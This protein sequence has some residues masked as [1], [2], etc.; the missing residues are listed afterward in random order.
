MEQVEQGVPKPAD[1]EIP[2]LVA[3]GEA[4]SCCR[5][6]VRFGRTILADCQGE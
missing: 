4:G 3:G 2:A 5:S 6:Q 1:A